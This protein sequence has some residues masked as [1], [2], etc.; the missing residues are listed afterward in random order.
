[1]K[2]YKQTFVGCENEK[3]VDVIYTKNI[4][5]YMSKLADELS[6]PTHEYYYDEE[7]MRVFDSYGNEYTFEEIKGE[8]VS[9]LKDLE[10]ESWLQETQAEIRI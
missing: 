4:V 2:K 8:I 1:M 9:E 10:N 3:I 5:K 6:Y 7:Q